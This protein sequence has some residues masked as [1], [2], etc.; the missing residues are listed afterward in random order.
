M[1]YMKSSDNKF[2]EIILLEEDHI[3]TSKE[4]FTFIS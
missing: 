1:A 3:A 4:L 2:W